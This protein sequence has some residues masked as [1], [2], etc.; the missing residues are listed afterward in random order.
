MYCMVTR[1]Y[2]FQ[3][4]LEVCKRHCTVSHRECWDSMLHSAKVC[5]HTVT[6]CY[7]HRECSSHTSDV[8]LSWKGEGLSR[9]CAVLSQHHDDVS[10]HGHGRQEAAQV[11]LTRSETTSACTVP[12]P[13]PATYRERNKNNNFSG[14]RRRA[15][16]SSCCCICSCQRRSWAGHA[17]G[18]F[19]ARPHP[20]K[21]ATEFFAN[22]SRQN[23]QARHCRQTRE[24]DPP[25]GQRST[26]PKLGIVLAAVST[27]AIS[28]TVLTNFT[29]V[30]NIS[31]CTTNLHHLDRLL[32][33]HIFHH[34]YYLQRL[35]LH[36][37]SPHS[38][39]LAGQYLSVNNVLSIYLILWP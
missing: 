28:I 10:R 4:A 25:A 24:V 16:W 35:H 5:Q 26:V 19:P 3:W 37:T 20:L 27:F 33:L 30:T 12:P 22:A 21:R 1:N 31:A 29:N 32:H 38:P 34:F 15:L 39:P 2:S 14:S 6:V 7:L 36:P 23:Q 8:K 13:S 17:H 9:R 11:G 18:H